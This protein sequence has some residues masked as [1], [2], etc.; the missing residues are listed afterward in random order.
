M[1]TDRGYDPELWRAMADE[2][3]WTALTID[4]AYGGFGLGM[5]DLVALVE[6]MGRALV[7]SPFFS[8]ICLG[9]AAIQCAGTEANKAELLPSLASGART[10]TLAMVEP[11]QRWRASDV[12]ATLTP[13]GDG[14]RLDG[15]KRYVVDGHTADLIVVVARAP[16]TVGDDGL[17]LVAVE[18]CRVQC[19]LQNSLDATR[20][21]ATVKLEAVE[22]DRAAVLGTPGEAAAPLRRTLDLAAIALAA[23]QV[24]GADQCLDM[25]VEYAKIRQQFGKPIGSFQAI[26][27]KCADM[28]LLVE[29]A[30]SAA[31]YAAWAADHAP[32]EL[33]SAA[34]MAKAYCSDAYFHCA[35]ENIQIHGGIGFTWEHDAHLYFKRARASATFL[36]DA[37]DHRERLA[38]RIEL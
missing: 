8:S 16:G 25:A 29:S 23:E 9:A 12:A 36:G 32:D 37:A 10:A 30:R 6:P 26:K 38:Q 22:V 17:S 31:Y 1:A 13:D 34:S 27:H 15:T 28:L 35:G 21:L 19:E 20:K 3:G 7:C 24:G 14:F 4:E 11:N 2:M 18:G 33:P 5:V